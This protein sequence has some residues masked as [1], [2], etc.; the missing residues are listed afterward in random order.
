MMPGREEVK[1]GVVVGVVDGGWWLVWKLVWRMVVGVECGVEGGAVVW[2]VG[3]ILNVCSQLALLL[4]P[5][6]DTSIH[7][8]L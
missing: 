6:N 2:V 3:V 7:I 8:C 1:V 4:D 5:H